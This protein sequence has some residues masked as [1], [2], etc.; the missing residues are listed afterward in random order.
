MPGHQVDH[1]QVVPVI[2]L[3]W[4]PYRSS[5]RLTFAGWMNNLQSASLTAGS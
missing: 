1:P 5:P 3:T 2:L 4:T